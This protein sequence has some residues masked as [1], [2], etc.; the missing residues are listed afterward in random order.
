VSAPVFCWRKGAITVEAL[1]GG[2][3]FLFRFHVDADQIPGDVLS[4]CV[5][6]AV[7]EFEA[8]VKA[9]GGRR[10]PTTAD[11]KAISEFCL[12]RGFTEVYWWRYKNGK[13]PK[14]I[15]LYQK[16]AY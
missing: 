11:R 14:Q 6:S 7:D 5:V 4:N 15:W 10:G 8:E 12:S 3:S 9:W 13:E 1:P 16:I 2:K